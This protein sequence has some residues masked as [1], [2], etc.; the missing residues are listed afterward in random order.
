[1]FKRKQKEVKKKSVFVQLDFL[2]RCK[3]AT[4]YVQ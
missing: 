3:A 1:M 2:M 4:C